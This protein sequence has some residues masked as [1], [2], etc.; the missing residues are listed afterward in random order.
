MVIQHI[1]SAFVADES[2]RLD[3]M[4]VYCFEHGRIPFG[5]WNAFDVVAAVPVAVD[6]D[7]CDRVGINLRFGCNWDL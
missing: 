2:F 1:H 7:K 3:E 6:F 4:P 5:F